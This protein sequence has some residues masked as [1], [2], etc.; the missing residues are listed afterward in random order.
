MAEETTVMPMDFMAVRGV[1][2]A[3]FARD[4]GYTGKSRWV[5]FWWDDADDDV[6]WN[7]GTNEGLGEG[8]WEVWTKVVA[9]IGAYFKHNHRANLG[10]AEEPAT[11]ML[12][13]D[14][15]QQIGFVAPNESVLEFLAERRGT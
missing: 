3:A 13:Y 14:R 15:G 6:A 4:L 2:P 5:A 11:H 8:A 10:G 12:L 7:D 9:P 1:Y